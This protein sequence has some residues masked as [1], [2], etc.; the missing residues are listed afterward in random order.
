M[1]E[2]KRTIHELS[3]IQDDLQ[4]AKE[5]NL[6]LVHRTVG[7]R[8]EP[9]PVNP[10]PL[11][12]TADELINEINNGGWFYTNWDLVDRITIKKALLKRIDELQQLLI[13]V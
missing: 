12:F 2:I 13:K 9:N 1:K 4:R 5:E 7:D 6:I 11:F 8:H 10:Y 3:R